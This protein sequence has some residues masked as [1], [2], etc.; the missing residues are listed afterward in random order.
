MK[1][2]TFAA[3]SMN[4]PNNIDEQQKNIESESNERFLIHL[5]SGLGLQISNVCFRREAN[6]SPQ[7]MANH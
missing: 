4:N 1:Y 5:G 3:R 2:D 6:A 7:L